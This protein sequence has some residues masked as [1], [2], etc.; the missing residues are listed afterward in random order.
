MTT[1]KCVDGSQKLLLAENT[2]AR[3]GGVLTHPDDLRHSANVVV[4]PVCGHDQSDDPGW[5]E[6]QVPQIRQSYRRIGTAARVYQDPHSAPDMQYDALAAAGPKESELEL[7]VTRGVGQSFH[8]PNARI[9][10][11]A[12]VLPSRKS[13]SVILGRSRNT[14]CDTRFFVPPGDRSYPMT[15]RKILPTLTVARSCSESSANGM[16]A[17]S[18]PSRTSFRPGN[19]HCG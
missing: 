6:A 13:R 18:C 11:L 1:F 7:V 2:G 4:V 14:I 8:R 9:A 3:E 19:G 15:Q 17:S 16:T 5:L 10:L 12:Q